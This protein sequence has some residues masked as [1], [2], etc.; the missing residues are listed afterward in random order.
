MRKG[1]PDESEER[2]QEQAAAE[3]GSGSV[4]RDAP[5]LGLLVV[6]AL[7]I[8][9]ALLAGL[10][11]GVVPSVERAAG[12]FRDFAGYRAAVLGGRPP[13][14][15]VGASVH[16]GGLAVALSCAATLAAFAIAA[17]ALFG[18]GLA[19]RLPRPLIDAPLQVIDMLRAA[20]SGHVGDYVAW[21]T[22]GAALLG[23]L[24]LWQ[25]AG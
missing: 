25:I 8:A 4:N 22:F 11:P 19:E 17:L 16:V 14:V 3:E 15:H 23:G 6:P 7:L 10:V 9:V 20:H 21:W 13:A 5:T 24:F 18:R 1:S 2:A 12:R